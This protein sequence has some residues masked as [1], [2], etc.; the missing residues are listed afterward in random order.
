MPVGSEP[1]PI[2][3]PPIVG[4][5][6]TFGGVAVEAPLRPVAPSSG[7]RDI[8]RSG[9]GT[10]RERLP[11]GSGTGTSQVPDSFRLGYPNYLREAK[12]GEVAVFALPGI[13]GIL[14]LTALGG[15]LGYRQAKASH[16]VRTAGTARFLR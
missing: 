13:V 5:P 11:T 14:A 8:A 10:G 16:V 15:F 3:L 9:E 6:T 7:P 4:G 1:A 2:H 12:I